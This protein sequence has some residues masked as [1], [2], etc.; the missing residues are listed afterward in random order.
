MLYRWLGLTERLSQSICHDRPILGPVTVIA[1]STALIFVHPRPLRLGNIFLGLI[2]LVQRNTLHYTSVRL[3]ARGWLVPVTAPFGAAM[4][5]RSFLVGSWARTISGSKGVF[6]FFC[7]VILG[8]W[9]K[10]FSSPTG[11]DFQ[12][13]SIENGCLGLSNKGRLNKDFCYDAQSVFKGCTRPAKSLYLRHFPYLRCFGWTEPSRRAE[14]V[15]KEQTDH[16]SITLGSDAFES[17][18]ALEAI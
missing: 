17:R 11:Y 13:G 3:Q 2:H 1:R 8:L 16:T 6:V 4:R 15:L 7:I 10:L 12:E 9:W 18:Q 14:L 5:D